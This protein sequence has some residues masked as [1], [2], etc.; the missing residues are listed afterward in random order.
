MSWGYKQGCEFVT[1]RCGS[2]THDRSAATESSAA[3]RGH[4]NWASTPD[5]YLAS[6]CVYGLSPCTTNVLSGYVDLGGS[7]GKVCDAQCHTGASAR[8]DCAEA[9]SSSVEAASLEGVLD[10]LRESLAS[11]SWQ[12]WLV[13]GV[14][15]IALCVP[16]VYILQ[17]VC[18][19][20]VCWCCPHGALP[21]QCLCPISKTAVAVT[22]SLA[23]LMMLVGVGIGGGCAYAILMFEEVAQY[24]GVRTLVVGAA[25]SG[26]LLL[27]SFL[28]VISTCMRA[29]KLM[30]GLYAVL[31][32]VAVVQ[33]LIC[34]LLVYWVHSL[35]GINFAMIGELV[36]E[37]AEAHATDWIA[38]ALA[39]PLSLIEGF[40]CT[41]YQLCCFD[42]ALRLTNGTCSQPHEGASNDILVALRD[43]SSDNF[44]AYLTGAPTEALITPPAGVCNILDAA[45]SDLSLSECRADFCAS[46][47]DGH[48]SFVTKVIG[49]IKRYAVPL[50]AGFGVLVLLQIVFAC[51]VRSARIFYRRARKTAPTSYR[52]PGE[53]LVRTK[54]GAISRLRRN[55]D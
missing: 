5:A 28:V 18:P 38:D 4:P 51:N 40:S 11:A 25:A 7:G 37:T 1:S 36:G 31:M 3:C 15:A 22:H 34:L 46:G 24:V 53:G 19:R 30:F 29:T 32:A 21:G 9:P 14:W 52:S 54:T 17:C 49:T 12:V 20:K 13:L 23:C 45:V 10:E 27:V 8:P 33:V 48:V 44:C 16:L 26:G 47:V 6:K 55:R 35:Q 2:G 41:T 39:A 43:P 50:G 42:P